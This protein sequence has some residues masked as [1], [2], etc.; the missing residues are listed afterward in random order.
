MARTGTPARFRAEWEGRP[1]WR[2]ACAARPGASAVYRVPLRPGPGP[3]QEEAHA[4]QRR[5]VRRTRSADR[6]A[7]RA[8]VHRPGGAGRQ[9]HGHLHLEPRRQQAPV[10]PG[11]RDGHGVPA[12]GVRRAAGDARRADATGGAAG[13]PGAGGAGHAGAVQLQPVLPGAAPERRTALD[14]H[15]GPRDHRPAGQ[16]G[17]GHRDHP[18]RQPGAARRRPDGGTAP[19][20]QRAAPPGRH[21]GARQRH[22]GPDPH[23]G[24]PRRGAHL[25]PAAG[26]D[27]RLQHHPGHGRRRAHPA[28]RRQR[29]PRRPAARLPPLPPGTAA[30]AHRGGPH[31]GGRLPPGPPGVRRAVPVARTVRTGVPPRPPRPSTSR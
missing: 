18:G 24:R 6:R 5:G 20:P 2:V 25:R 12:R 13:G 23:P 1:P 21:R 29:H 30:A 17:A 11:R 19:R 4:A 22:P 16:A 26:A 9:Q 14:P 31:P 15:P 28:D 7:V 10:R 27:R 3:G 8:P